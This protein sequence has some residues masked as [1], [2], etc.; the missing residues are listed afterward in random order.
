MKKRAKWF[1][2]AA[3]VTALAAPANAL[4]QWGN[5]HWATSGSGLTLRIERQLTSNWVTYFN[6]SVSDWNSSD[7]LSLTG[8]TS[9]L[10][11]SA[12][13][14][15]PIAGKAL[16]CN[17][18]Y[19]QRGWL[20]IASIWA[21]GDHIT[22]A[23][24]K[25]NDS[26][27]NLSAYNTPGWRTMVACQEIGHDFGLDHQD[28]NFDNAN[29]G[30]CMDYTSDPNRNDGAGNNLH[31]NA[32]DYATLDFMYSHDDG[33]GGGGGGGGNCNPRSPK[34]NGQDAFTFRQVGKPAQSKTLDASPGSWGRAIGYDRSGR[35]NEFELDLGNGHRRI[36]HV[37]WVPGHRPL[38]SEMH[39]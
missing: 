32:D 35:A 20:G 15:D 2:A 11:V 23:T 18:S 22:Q 36:T 27:F 8:A 17:D 30:T 16:V 14:C 21:N 34:C 26:Y 33:S 19:G 10:G 7:K 25:L 12:K 6:G 29:L 3:A 28:E 1:V 38:K 37:F 5:Y 31:P 24:T 13:R 39:D 4:N 9:N